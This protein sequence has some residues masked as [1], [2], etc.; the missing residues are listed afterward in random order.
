MGTSDELTDYCKKMVRY[1]GKGTGIPISL[2]I[3]PTKTLAKM[4]SKVA[5]KHKG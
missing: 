3:A 5:K 1:I 4:A 2:G